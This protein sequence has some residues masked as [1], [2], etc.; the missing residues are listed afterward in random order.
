MAGNPARKYS[1]AWIVLLPRFRE[2]AI[3]VQGQEYIGKIE[4]LQ[5]G[6]LM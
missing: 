2:I 3:V 4:V 5:S 6:K 1:A